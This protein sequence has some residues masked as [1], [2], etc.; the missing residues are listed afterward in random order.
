MK[1]ILLIFCV[2][3]CFSTSI[4]SQIQ[5]RRFTAPTSLN[6]FIDGDPILSR[7]VRSYIVTNLGKIPNV[8]IDS[9]LYSRYA[10]TVNVIRDP[11]VRSQ[12]HPIYYYTTIVGR[13]ANCIYPQMPTDVKPEPCLS[14]VFIFGPERGSY[15]RLRG[16]LDDLFIMFSTT[17]VD[18]DRKKFAEDID[19][20]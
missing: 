17:L 13:H 8:S 15:Q 16:H 3:L 6:I 9:P 10:F 2:V 5:D 12:Q 1:Q 7:E 11:L 20:Q 4:V 19:W 18:A 14:A